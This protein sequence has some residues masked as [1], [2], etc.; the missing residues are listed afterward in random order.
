MLGGR[1][2]GEGSDIFKHEELLKVIADQENKCN[3]ES[4]GC[5]GP[6]ICRALGKCWHQG[7]LPSAHSTSRRLASSVP[8]SRTQIPSRHSPAAGEAMPAA[9][10]CVSVKQLNTQLPATAKGTKGRKTSCCCHSARPHSP[11][12]GA[13]GDQRPSAYASHSLFVEHLL[14]AG[15]VMS[16]LSLPS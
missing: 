6:S 5:P 16:T 2:M 10:P 13:N 8:P 9:V 12:P 3:S 11:C 7:H 4:A 1:G 15:S 14:C